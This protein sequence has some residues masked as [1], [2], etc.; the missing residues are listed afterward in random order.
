MYVKI[1]KNSFLEKGE[2]MPGMKL[3]FAP[4]EG[5]TTYMYR[6]IHNE[7]FGG[8]DAYY[9]PFITPSDNEKI[10]RKGFRDVLPVNNKGVNLK[11]Q[12]LT[13]NTDS[14]LKFVDRIREDGHNEVNLNLGCPSGTVTGKG[15]GSG[16][17][18]NPEALD[19]FFENIFSK[20][21]ATITVKTRL[22]FSEPT[23]MEKLIQ[24][25][26]KY[27]I[28]ELTVH[29]RTRADFYK[30]ALHMDAFD[31]VYEMSKNPLCYNGDIRTK[32]DYFRICEKY[33]NLHGVMIGR[34]A[35]INPAIFREINGGKSVITEELLKF[36]SKLAESYNIHLDAPVFTLH[37]MKEVWIF[38]MENYPE[39]TK[40]LKAVRKSNKLHELMGAV[41]YLPEIKKL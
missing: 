28:K 27:P 35:I 5:I 41:E 21:D 34:G 17:L 10:G 2:K 31:K 29:P 33:P 30:G 37:K 13:N 23:E 6:N 26:N 9:A 40:I 7:M 18:K 36:S 25:Y 14:F 12:V 19:V 32:E 4:L 15:R 1:P 38:M 3:Y 11:L 8:C 22:G 39:E 16:L 24:I 20:T